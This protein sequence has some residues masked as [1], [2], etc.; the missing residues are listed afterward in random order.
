MHTRE[1]LAGDIRKLGIDPGDTVM[2]HASIRSVGEVAGGPDQIHLALKDV[3]SP[4]GTL[5]MYAGCPLYCD[6]VG[7]GILTKEQ[8]QEIIEKLPAFDPLTA[9]SPRYPQS[10]QARSASLT[11]YRQT[12][13]IILLCSIRARNSW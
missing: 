11:P 3:L 13:G 2:L 12:A 5:L 1:Q 8:E 10:K 6:E 7:S 4:Q 9:R